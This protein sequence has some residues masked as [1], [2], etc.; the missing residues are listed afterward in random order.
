MMD[1]AYQ[2]VREN[3]GAG[4]VDGR[5]FDSLEEKEGGF[6][7]YLA[8][9]QR[10]SGGR[11]IGPSQCGGCKF[12]KRWGRRPLGIPMIKGRVVQME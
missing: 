1:H 5:T 4:G 8:E 3:K 9:M 6:R 7:K 10:N 11:S 2:L 12:R